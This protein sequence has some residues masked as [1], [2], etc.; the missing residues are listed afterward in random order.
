MHTEKWILQKVTLSLVHVG[1]IKLEM[2]NFDVIIFA[3][4]VGKVRTE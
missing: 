3:K 2:D 1:L 4:V